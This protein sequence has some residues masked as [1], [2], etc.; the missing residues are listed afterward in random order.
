MWIYRE[1]SHKNLARAKHYGADAVVQIE[2]SLNDCQ[3]SECDRKTVPC[4]GTRN[5]KCSMAVCGRSVGEGGPQW[6]HKIQTKFKLACF[7]YAERHRFQ[8]WSLSNRVARSTQ[9][10]RFKWDSWR[11]FCEK[12]RNVASGQ[13]GQRWCTV[14]TQ[15]STVVLMAVQGGHGVAT[16]DQRTYTLIPILR[17]IKLYAYINCSLCWN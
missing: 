4:C 2:L 12:V 5:R 8:I 11:N 6:P 1:R 17:R 15:W 14:A 10:C 7:Y 3:V 13:C 16:L 9:E